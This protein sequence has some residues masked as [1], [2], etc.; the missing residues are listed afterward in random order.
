MGAV[1]LKHSVAHRQIELFPVLGSC[2]PVLLLVPVLPWRQVLQQNP[3]QE[4]QMELL[5]KARQRGVDGRKEK[6]TDILH[7]QLNEKLLFLTSFF[8]MMSPVFLSA[9]NGQV[10]FFMC[11]Q[12]QSSSGYS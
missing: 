3:Q 8:A 2:P 1:R 11:Y 7:I 9:S 5:E 10:F 12:R 4:L 6:K